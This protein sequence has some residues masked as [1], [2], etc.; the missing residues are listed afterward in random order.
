ME[1][2]FTPLA[3]GSNAGLGLCWAEAPRCTKYGA[4]M[5]EALMALGKDHTLRLYAEADALHLV[6]QVLRGDDVKVLDADVAVVSRALDDLV[7]ACTNADGKPCTPD[8]GA[9]MR[10]RSML[11]P[12]C[13][14]AL[15]K[16]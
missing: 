15:K 1:Q 10:A 14:H 2:T 6:G 5:M 9:V 4:G 7:G 8:R 13:K 3:V 16:A 12:A 11:P